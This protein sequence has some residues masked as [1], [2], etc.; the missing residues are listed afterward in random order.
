MHRTP[1]RIA[2]HFAAMVLLALPALADVTRFDLSGVATDTT[3]AVLP[4][5]TINLSN[6]DTGFTRSTV[7]DEAGRYSFN[8]V[9]PTGKWTLEAQLQGFSSQKREGLEFQANTRPVI[10]FQLSVGA[11]SEV[12]TVQAS[13]PLVRTRESELSSI[14]D[15][16]Q[17]DALPTN[18]RNFLTLLQTSGSV[19]PTGSGSLALSINGQGTRMANFLADGVSMTGREIRSLNGEFGGGNGL[20]LDVVKELQVITN[21]F[22]AE[23]G[24]TGAGTVSVITKSGTNTLSG[25]AYGFWRP[26]DFVAANLLN[27]AATTQSRSQ[28]GGTIGGP[29]KKDV[30]HYFANYEDTTIND[31][32]VVTS[33]L[34]PGTFAAPQKQ[35]Q[36]FFKVDH[37]FSDHNS[38]DVR[39]NFNRNTQE[40]QSVGGLNTYDRRTNTVGRTDGFV[41]SLLSNFGSNKVNVAR[42]RYTFDTVD[43]YS[44]LTASSGAASR[45]PD[46]STAPVSV[47]YTGVGNLGTNPSYPQNLVEKRA[48]WVDQFSIVH[49]GHQFKSGVD[50]IGSWRFV[51]LF[52]NFP[53]TYTFAQGTKFPFNASDPSTFPIQFTQTFGISGLNFKDAL[54]G[55]F[56]Q[57]DWEVRRGLTLNLG[58]RWDKDS[59]FQGD[60]NNF[61]PRLGFAWNPDGDAKTVLRGGTGIFYDTLESS[62]INRESNT[63][64]VG[65]TT[66]DLRQGDPLFPTFPNRLSAFPTGTATV[67]RALVYVPIF[68]GSDFPLGIGDQFHRIA[69]HFFNTNVGVQH[70][71]SANW[72]LSADYTRVYGYDLLTTFD[73][74]APPYFALGPGQT[75]TLAQADRL[76]PLGSP[77]TTGGPFGIDFTGF[78]TLYLQDNG[79]STQYN[80]VK[81]A[82]T[83]RLSQ[84]YSLQANYTLGRARGDVD[85]FRAANSFVPGL[86][87]LGGDRSYQFGPSDTDVRH[88]FV[89]N[90]T[91]LAPH[92]LRVGAILFARSGFPYTGVVGTDANG[93]GFTSNGSFGDRP[94]SLTRNSYRYPA[95]V[96]IDTSLAYDLRLAGSHVVELR[97]DIFNLGNKR[98]VTTVNNIVGL[99]PN[100]PP[101]TFGTVTGVGAQRQAQIAVR[102]RF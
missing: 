21:G 46:F 28:Y 57:D 93:D 87:T 37:R 34:G 8:A 100:N 96:T 56:T 23:T 54:I 84:N 67:P 16:K 7:T 77:N 73:I 98:N 86:T 44:P 81:F 30:A 12:M 27:G 72:A 13:A 99:D 70:E 63:G 39:Y 18:G 19:V 55:V 90:G 83:K 24:Q 68:Q 102:Y 89:V 53:G 35:R 66:I 60:N 85:N 20:S 76:R 61:A 15:A 11:L 50:V 82:L 49:G 47:V 9:P 88:V 25:S 79:G 92:G 71:L 74:N 14:L 3:G 1:I 52:N 65:Q 48:Q 10:N 42:F 62:M 64:P 31:A 29:I 75:R 5:V 51:T 2:A 91:Y 4:G 78:R 38:L 101:A 40:G 43:F 17:V 59:L 36:G 41:A 45:T 32:A 69:P 22:K 33:V 97:F 80:A 26:T 58:V 95:Q 6:T 94:A